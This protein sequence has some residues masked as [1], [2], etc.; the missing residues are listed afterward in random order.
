MA[1]DQFFF[2]TSD[3]RT[4]EFTTEIVAETQFTLAPIVACLLRK[5]FVRAP[6]IVYSTISFLGTV[7]L[8]DG[9]HRIVH[10]L[11]ENQEYLDNVI[12][13]LRSIFPEKLPQD[14]RAQK[15]Y[16]AFLHSLAAGDSRN[17]ADV[18]AKIEAFITGDDPDP[19]WTVR[20]IVHVEKLVAEGLKGILGK[21]FYTRFTDGNV[22]IYAIDGGRS[23]QDRTVLASMTAGCLLLIREKLIDMTSCVLCGSSDGIRRCPDCL[24]VPYC[25]AGPCME[26]DRGRHGPACD[27]YC[28]HPPK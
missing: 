21:D 10:L 14:E 26:A 12:N 3:L 13:Y 24:S 17:L 6:W 20:P 5:L 1:Q 7:P 16:F 28:A 15:K 23:S 11:K 18:F 19:E 4:L 27:L 2:L 22:K 9:G 8:A 25:S